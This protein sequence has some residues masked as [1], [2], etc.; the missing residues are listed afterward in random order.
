M[1]LIRGGEERD[2]AA[3]VAMGQVRASPFRFHVDREVDFVST[4]SRRNGCLQA[5]HRRHAAIALLIAEEA[6]TAA[7]VRC[8][9]HRR[10]HIDH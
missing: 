7:A 10:W 4:R 8:R 1:T 9:Q 2:W 5:R 6:I 3:I